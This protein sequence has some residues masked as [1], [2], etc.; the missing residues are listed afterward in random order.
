[1]PRKPHP[2]GHRHY[3]WRH[4]RAGEESLFE[5]LVGWRWTAAMLVGGSLAAAAVLGLPARRRPAALRGLALTTIA[6]AVVALLEGLRGA[7]FPALRH[8]DLPIE[9]L[10]ES[11]D[12]FRIGQLTDLHLGIPLARRAVRRAVAAVEAEH[13]DLLVL[14]GDYIS[15]SRHLPLLHRAL[16]PLA[17]PYG[18]YAIFG[19]HDHWTNPDAIGRVLCGMGIHLLINAHATIAKDDAVLVVAGVDDIWDGAPDLD[20]ALAGSRPGAP[21]ILLAHA[22]DYADTAA[23]SPIAVQLAG[24]T[25]AGHIRLPGLGP[26]FLPRHGVRYDRGLHRVGRMWLYVSHGVGGL[27]VRIGS[28]GEAT[29]FTLR[30]GGRDRLQGT[31]G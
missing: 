28:R 26:L 24:H 23:L 22:P 29:I 5:I 8:I 4:P 27:P 20:T 6:A 1:M 21:V 25:H 12:G 9:G 18:I 10:P 14:T 13:P 19:N 31:G 3:A 15:F 7:A 16:R 2:A 11:F 17:A 30:R